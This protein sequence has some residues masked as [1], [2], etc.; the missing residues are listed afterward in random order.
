MP[1]PPVLLVVV[2][3][4]KL[5][6][7]GSHGL[8]I[9]L[10]AHISQDDPEHLWK[11]R[12]EG[13]EEEWALLVPCK[14]DLRHLMQKLRRL[15]STQDIHGAAS[16]PTGNLSA[17]EKHREAPLAAHKNHPSAYR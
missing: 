8:H 9:L 4:P 17:D 7:L 13:E 6:S 10:V 3:G 1:P 14:A 5:I 16:L 15:P 12:K 2:L 11:V